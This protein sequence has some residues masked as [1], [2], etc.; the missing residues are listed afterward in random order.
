MPKSG[1]PDRSSVETEITALEAGVAKLIEELTA[2]RER[3]DRAEADH[4]QL[5]DVLRRSNVDAGD[6]KSLERRL[7]ELT[8]E[9]AVLRNVIEEA[10][11]R[12]ERIR[13]RLIVMED[14]SAA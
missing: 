6:P 11:G 5:D 1:S 8:E 4:R 10:R 3:A 2:T 12:A 7:R 13:S 9:N 14:E